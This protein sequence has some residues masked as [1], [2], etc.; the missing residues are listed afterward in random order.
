MWAYQISP[1]SQIIDTINYLFVAAFDGQKPC[2]DNLM[3]V[4]FEGGIP[5]KL[6]MSLSM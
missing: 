4:Y 1:L 3:L 2:R 5:S 6:S